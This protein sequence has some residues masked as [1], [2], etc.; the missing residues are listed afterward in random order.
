MSI[1][2]CA[3]HVDHG[4]LVFAVAFIAVAFIAVVLVGHLF[5]RIL[6]FL[7]YFVAFSIHIESFFLTAVV[8]V[9]VERNAWF[10]ERPPCSMA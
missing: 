10:E 9:A 1:A 7:V 6:I 5:V 4:V 8:L 3:S 2:R